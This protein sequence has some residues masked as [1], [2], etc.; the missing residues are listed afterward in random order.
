MPGL[1]RDEIRHWYNG[2]SWLGAEKVYN[3][4]DILLLFR[5]RRFGAWWFETATPSFLIETLARRGV[6]SV[7]LDGMLSS[8]D[9]LS[10]FDAD[11]IAP[12]ALLFQTGY[13]TIRRTERRGSDTYYRLG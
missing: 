5:R 8:G 10:E 4:F 3:P 9:L 7:D 6:R 12:E 13:L 1:D 2:Y 11:R